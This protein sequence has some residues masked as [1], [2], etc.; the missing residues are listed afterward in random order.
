MKTITEK[1]HI[2]ETMS[3]LYINLTDA[4]FESFDPYSKK[5]DQKVDVVILMCTTK[6]SYLSMID[7]LKA[8]TLPTSMIWVGYPKSKGK[9]RYDINRDILFSLGEIAGLTPVA[10]VAYDESW[11]MVRLKK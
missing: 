5:V 11:S 2:K 7:T 3:V 10:N 8:K 6:V 4:E 1:M 9:L